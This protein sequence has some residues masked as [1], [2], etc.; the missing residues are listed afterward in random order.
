MKNRRQELKCPATMEGIPECSL[1]QALSL[2]MG[3]EGQA[4]IEWKKMQLSIWN[5]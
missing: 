4:Y 2:K 5:V 1:K 3:G